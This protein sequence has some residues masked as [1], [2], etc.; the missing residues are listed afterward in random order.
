MYKRQADTLFEIAT[1]FQGLLKSTED[2]PIHV[3]LNQADLLSE[4]MLAEIKLTAKKIR[5]NGINCHIVSLI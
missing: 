4:Q 5:D 1:S 3:I 2:I